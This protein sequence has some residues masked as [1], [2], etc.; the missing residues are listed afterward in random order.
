M[1]GQL[2]TLGLSPS[3]EEGILNANRHG[4]R[5][6]SLKNQRKAENL[7]EAKSGDEVVEIT[8]SMEEQLLQC[9]TGNNFKI[10]P[11]E[12]EVKDLCL[13]DGAEEE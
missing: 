11:I 6:L 9:D 8:D 5:S 3:Q 2:T 1:K 13:D 7:L 4:R 10:S 12:D